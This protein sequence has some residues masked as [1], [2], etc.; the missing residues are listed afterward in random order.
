MSSPGVPFV[1]GV[2]ALSTIS[3]NNESTLESQMQSSVCII[4]NPFTISYLFTCSI[5]QMLISLK[6]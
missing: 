3:Q 2:I 5:Y 6:T 1:T 4:I